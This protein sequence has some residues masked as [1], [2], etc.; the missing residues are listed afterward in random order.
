MAL[1]KPPYSVRGVTYQELVS[2]LGCHEGFDDLHGVLWYSGRFIANDEEVLGV[3][4]LEVVI[5]VGGDTDRVPLLVDLVLCFQNV[6]AEGH[7]G[8]ALGLS[9]FSPE[10]VFYLS[11]CR[12]C[13]HDNGVFESEQEGKD[14][15]CRR[16]RFT[17]TVA[18]LDRGPLVSENG[19]EYFVLHAPMSALENP[20]KEIYRVFDNLCLELL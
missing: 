15:P 9:Y 4:T 17:N 13:G 3:E 6:T 8:P 18:R 14:D 20:V 2:S 1:I 16:V 12:G 19:Q 11:E 5:F 7:L 10:D